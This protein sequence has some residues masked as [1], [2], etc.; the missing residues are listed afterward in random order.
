MTKL[1]QANTLLVAA[2]FWASLSVLSAD[3]ASAKCKCLPKPKLH[4][5]FND[6]KVVVIGRVSEQEVNPIKPGYLEVKITVLRKFKTDDEPR[7]EYLVAY[8]P[9]S[10]ED[11]GMELQPGFEYLFYLKGNPA[12]YTVDVCGRSQLLDDASEDVN[13]LANLVKK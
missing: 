13:A 2:V 9:E 3:T 8:T 4:M 5:A 1:L 11:C 6:A 7:V 12:F 10:A